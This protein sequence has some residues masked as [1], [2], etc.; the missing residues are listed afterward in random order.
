MTVSSARRLLPAIAL[1]ALSVGLAGCMGGGTTYGTG[2]NPGAQTLEDLAGIAS[3]GAPKK[4]P[5]DYAARAPLVPPPVGT[6]LPPPGSQASVAANWPKDPDVEQKKFKAE[7]KARAQAQAPGEQPYGI[8]DPKF[9]VQAKKGDEPSPMLT[10]PNKRM[11]ADAHTTTEQAS[12]SKKLFADARGSPTDEN[13]QPIRQ[14]LTDP[15]TG[16]RAPDPTAP[17]EVDAKPAVKKKFKW[18][19]Q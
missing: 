16:Y 15:P 11:D 5:I 4:D 9:R 18:P 8:N 17:V 13:G 2:K 3:M 19:W 1:T 10:D 6:P 14:Y 7:S 12:A